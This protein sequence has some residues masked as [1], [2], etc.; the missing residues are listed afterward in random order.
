LKILVTGATGL[1]G[2]ALCPFLAGSDHRVLRMVRSAPAQ[3]NEVQWDPSSGKLDRSALEGLDAV[4]HLAG[5]SIASGRWTAE[6]KRRILQSRIR[7]TGLLS[8]SLAN[9]QSPPE[10]LISVSAVGYYGDRGEEQLDEESSPGTGF[11][12][13]VCRQWEG[14]TAP[15]SKG[16]IR[17]VIPR[18][19]VVLSAAGGALALMLPIYRMGIGGR[20]GSGQQY[21]SWIAIDDIVRIIDYAIKSRSLAGPLNAVSPNPVT[22]SAFSKTLA[23]VLS[24][25]AIFGLPGFAARLAFGEMAEETLL[26][27]T[28]ATPKRLMKSS[29]SFRFPKLDDA[30]RHILRAQAECRN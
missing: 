6:K 3:A 20:I 1:I 9:L 27:S 11:L 5:E 26:S 21:M 22:N 8:R 23:H 12:P 30:L 4:V 10:V 13:E 16:G 18:I 14:A 19:G 25:P 17:V 7:G 24:R 29:F 28:R 2:S 15:A